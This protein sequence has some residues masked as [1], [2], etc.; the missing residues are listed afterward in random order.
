MRTRL[1]FLLVA[2]ALAL[3]GC[4]DVPRD[5]AA[6]VAPAPIASV[7]SSAAIVPV[8]APLE[9]VMLVVR[10]SG[11]DKAGGA[12]VFDELLPHLAERLPKVFIA[13]GLDTRVLGVSKFGPDDAVWKGPSLRV[14]T[15]TPLTA[16]AF[17]RSG[18][19]LRFRAVLLDPARNVPLWH[20]DLSVISQGD[21]GD[22]RIA[23]ELAVKLLTALRGDR[24]VRPSELAVQLP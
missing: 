14:L 23:D 22:E 7:P 12:E 9:R 19:V 4:A 6:V 20:A 1:L 24:I 13:N 15:V 5:A 18:Q 8:Q 11:A 3:A 10:P 2:G 16:R 21:R 17:K